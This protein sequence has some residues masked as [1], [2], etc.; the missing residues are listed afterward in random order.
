M[1]TFRQNAND[2]Y[3]NSNDVVGVEKKYNYA[4]QVMPSD[5]KQSHYTIL[6]LS[7]VNA[8]LLQTARAKVMSPNNG[9]AT[10]MRILFDS[11]SQLSYITP[12]AR[13][14]LQLNS[15]GM[16]NIHLKTSGNSTTDKQLEKVKVLVQTRDSLGSTYLEAFV[17]HI[18]Y[19]IEQQVI[20][21]AK[22][23]YT[24][25]QTLSMA[26]ENPENFPL[27]ID[28]LVGASYY[29]DFMT[30]EI[31][32]GRSGPVALSSKLGYILSGSDGQVNNSSSTNACISHVLKVESTGLNPKEINKYNLLNLYGNE[33]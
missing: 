1:C 8:V 2:P 17:S 29:W 26:D 25:L 23:E 33:E 3:N 12:E 27:R 4:G 20:N 16:Y 13:S 11:G 24:H 31:I 30:G 5:S 6:N 22:A 14:F 18:C 19:P 32:R 9:K 21:I 10:N 7:K 15:L 28:I